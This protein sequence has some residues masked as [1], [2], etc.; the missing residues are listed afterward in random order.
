[1][2]KLVGPVH[3]VGS[4]CHVGLGLPLDIDPQ[5]QQTVL[6]RGEKLDQPI[7]ETRDDFIT[8]QGTCRVKLTAFPANDVK[9]AGLDR[10]HLMMV[11]NGHEHTSLGAQLPRM[12]ALEVTREDNPGISLIQNLPRMN[13]PQCPVAILTSSKIVQRTGGIPFVSLTAIYTGM[14][15]PKLK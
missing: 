15:Q 6:A 2:T 12:A 4:E 11:V 9:P 13:V 10:N 8:L 14:Q 7:T 5:C 3:G 1:M